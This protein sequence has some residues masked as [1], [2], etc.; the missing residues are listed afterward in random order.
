MDRITK[1]IYNGTSLYRRTG[2]KKS[3]KEQV[4]NMHRFAKWLK[5]AHPEVKSLGQLGRR[6]VC[7]FWRSHAEKSESYKRSLYYSI[8]YIWKEILHRSSEPP[9]FEKI[10]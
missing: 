6:Q 4:M 8:R 10:K 1:E 3:R 9:H 5:Q 7:N 2:G